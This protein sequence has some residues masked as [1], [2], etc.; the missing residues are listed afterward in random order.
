MTNTKVLP[1]EK[2]D[3]LIAGQVYPLLKKSNFTKDGST[4]RQKADGVIKV[5]NFQKS[6]YNDTESVKFYINLGLYWIDFQSFRTS[7][8]PSKRPKEYDCTIRRR[9]GKS[10]EITEKTD[11]GA[12][13]EEVLKLL[14]NEGMS[15]LNKG[16]TPEGALALLKEGK[17]LNQGTVPMFV[18]VYSL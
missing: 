16:S 3:A 17:S 6:P 12:L 10:W 2:Y 14:A 5:V 9:L 7:I 13:C 18:K 11:F 4:F 8:L 15:W 1:K